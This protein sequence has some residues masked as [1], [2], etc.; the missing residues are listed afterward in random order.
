M[1]ALQRLEVE[2]VV[3]AAAEQRGVG[4]RGVAVAAEQ[5]GAEGIVAVAAEERD[6]R[7][8][9]VVAAAEERHLGV[10]RVLVV[11]A[12]QEGVYALERLEVEDVVAAAA[13]QRRVD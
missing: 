12:L 13:E 11:A 8:Q 7:R 6:V 5:G 2:D 1:H 4:R 3:A 9:R 10:E